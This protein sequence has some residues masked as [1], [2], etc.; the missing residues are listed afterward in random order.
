MF[1]KIRLRDRL[2]VAALFVFMAGSARASILSANPYPLPDGTGF[3][4]LANGTVC[5]SPTECTGFLYVEN[6]AAVAE[7][8]LPN[9]EELASSASLVATFSNGATLDLKLVSGTTFDVRLTG[10]YDP[11]TNAVGGF[12]ET[13]D[14]PASP[15]PTALAIRSPLGWMAARPQAVRRSFLRSSAAMKS[16]IRR[17]CMRR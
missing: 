5:V 16:T 4:L 14:R 7:S 15:A 13:W 12:A 11:L 1:A 6:L 3:D 10:G 17:R 2:A 8:A 9:G